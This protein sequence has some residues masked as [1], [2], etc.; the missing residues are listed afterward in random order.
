MYD[1]EVIDPKTKKVK[2]VKRSKKLGEKIT[3]YEL[4]GTEVKPKI[5]T[6]W[7][8]KK[9]QKAQL[10]E[11]VRFDTTDG[12]FYKEIVPT[13]EQAEIVAQT[14]FVFEAPKWIK[15]RLVKK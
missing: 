11:K 1:E 6:I 12:K 3:G 7:E 8:T 13:P 14:G 10:K 15:D 2:I 5:E 4:D 9:V